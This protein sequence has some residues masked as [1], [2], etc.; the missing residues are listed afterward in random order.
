MRSRAYIGKSHNS[1]PV[2]LI[3]SW[4]NY[5]VMEGKDDEINSLFNK[6]ALML[7][8]D[9]IDTEKCYRH[10]LPEQK[11]ELIEFIYQMSLALYKLYYNRDEST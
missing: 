3:L 5:K 10:L 6:E 8:E 9:E 2:H 11:R 4:L 1:G 7:T